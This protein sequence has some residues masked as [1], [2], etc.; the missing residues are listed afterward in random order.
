M[1]QVSLP[2]W[3][4]GAAPAEIVRALLRHLRAGT[5]DQLPAELRLD[6]ALF[7]DPAIARAEIEGVFGSVPFVAA[8]SSEVPGPFRYITKRLPRNEAVILRVGDGTLRAYVNM[9]RHRGAQLLT[10]DAGTCRVFSCPYHGWSYDLEGHLKRI[11]FAESFGRSPGGDLGLVSLPVEERHGFI[12]IIDQPGAAIDVAAWLG[13]E[14]DGI[15]RGYR[16]DLLECYRSGTFDQPV[17]WK[18]MHDAFLDGYHIKFAHPASAGRVIHTNTY[19]VEDHGR[20]CRFASPRKSLDR[21][22]DADPEPDEPMLG[23]VMITHFL[24]PNCTLLQLEDHFEI[25]TFYP[26]S[27]DPGESRMEM[28]LLVPHRGDEVSEDEWS[29]K[30]DKNWRILEVVLTGEDFPILRSI[31]RAYAGASATPTLLG[32]NEVLNQVFHREIERLRSSW[33]SGRS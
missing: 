22:L 18:I 23:H 21:W 33:A 28:K 31:Q 19:V 1:S 13:P 11:T 26:V 12:W 14:M 29:N 7:T 8:H 27:Q 25:L 32:R 9:C 2:A 6:P 30:W 3:H 5:T 20:H 4:P 17:N 10:D 24:G 16:M 15:L